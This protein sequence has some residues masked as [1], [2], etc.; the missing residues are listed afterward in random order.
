MNGHINGVC[1]TGVVS[2]VTSIISGLL[3]MIILIVTP[4]AMS[5]IQM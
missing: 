2:S 3:N 5:L 1:E 4:G